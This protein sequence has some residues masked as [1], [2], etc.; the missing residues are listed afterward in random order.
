MTPQLVERDERTVA[1]ENAG[2]R[3]SY[4]V[5]S[6]ALLVDV[7]FRSFVRGE[8]SWD[9]FAL[10]VLSGGLN[11]GYQAWKRALFPRWIV[12]VLAV[13]AGAAAVAAAIAMLRH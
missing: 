3:W 12:I 13:V 11:A 1:I 6:F 7:A 10:I 2:Y 5:L 8:T 4:L 9:L